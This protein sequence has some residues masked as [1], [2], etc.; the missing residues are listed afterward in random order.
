MFKKILIANRGEIA[1]RVIR[2]CREME[3]PTVA[4]YSE[5]DRPSLHV[6]YA[7]E[8][9]CIGPPPST[10]SYLAM[11]KIIEVA[12]KTQAEAIH[13]GYGFLAENA[14]FAGLCEREG[15]TFI[16]PSSKAMRV[17]GSK[18]SARTL[19]KEV[20]VPVVPGTTHDLTDEEVAQT[21]AEM[22]YPILI[23]A[24][25]GGGG[26]GMRIVASD[27]ELTSA[28][29]AARSEASS[30]FG[31]P[32]IYVEKYL[33]RP[34]HIEMQILGDKYGDVIYLGERECSIQRRHQKV[35][36][37]SPSPIITPDLR[38]RM[39]EAAV[40]LA[41][42]S[43]YNNAGTMEFLVDQDR[44]FYFL[45][46]NARLQVEHPVT[47][48]VTGIDLVKEQILI[49]AGGKL[50]YRQ[51]DIK[52]R[53]AAIECRIYAEDPDN[54]FM[55]SPGKIWGLRSPG[56]PGVRDESGVYEGY[57]VPLYYDPLISKLVAWGRDREE[58]LERMRRALREYVIQGIK[59]TIPFHRRVL[60][61]PD[62]LKGDFDTTFIETRFA[63][64][65][66]TGARRHQEVAL[67]AAAIH[68]YLKEKRAEVPRPQVTAPATGS[69]WKM[70]ARQDGLRRR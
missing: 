16:G 23:K 54:N 44:S 58:A 42:A 40:A 55:P 3:I 68:A 35:I 18:T 38:R 17:T 9:F 60:E 24:A 21:A 6:R 7:D 30:S 5:A 46:V 62:F 48:M 39:G 41:K 31:D 47:E 65:A 52:L 27:E 64:R 25:G 14:A 57:E 36:E 20:G 19:A 53:G 37:E 4:V 29:R 67:I 34:R 1:V 63:E 12:K 32:A 2:A 56:G 51:E 43:G 15:I 66:A 13:P 8:A 33:Q 26:K 69:P 11:D 10:E 22:G 61:D 59:T 49:A 28:I 45:E 50:R 70:A